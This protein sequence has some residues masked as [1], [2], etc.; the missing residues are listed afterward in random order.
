MFHFSQNGKFTVPSIKDESDI[1]ISKWISDMSDKIK[2]AED[3]ELS[4]YIS[5][6]EA[7]IFD[8]N[9]IDYTQ[10]LFD[11]LKIADGKSHNVIPF[12]DIGMR[13]YRRGLFELAELAFYEAGAKN[14]L[15]YMI[16]RKEVKNPERYTNKYVAELL[17]EL[18]HGKESFSM[19]NM[20]LLWALNI[21]TEENWKLADDI[22]SNLPKDEIMRAFYWWLDVANNGEVEGYLVHYW[23]LKNGIIDYTPLGTKE[24]LLEK[25]MSEI[26]DLPEFMK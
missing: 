19:I 10:E 17:Q 16:R 4:P 12:G 13:A 7:S 11:L 21:G 8:V 3:Y 1:D 18:V 6:V 26:K 23:M 22:M 14:N 20:S 25:V 5:E 2:G 24:Y 9:N 15:A